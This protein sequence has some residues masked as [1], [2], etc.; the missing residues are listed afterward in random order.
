MK[1]KKKK[2]YLLDKLCNWT[3]FYVIEF[4]YINFYLNRIFKL[5]FEEQY[6]EAG[7]KSSRRYEIKCV[8]FLK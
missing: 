2:N 4:I 6:S 5:N 1:K 7:F 8:A 3:I